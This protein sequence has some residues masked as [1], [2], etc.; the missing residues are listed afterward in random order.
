MRS[1]G[2]RNKRICFVI[3][4]CCNWRCR[5]LPLTLCGTS[6]IT[7]WMHYDN[8]GRKQ[9]VLF[10]QQQQQ[11]PYKKKPF[12]FNWKESEL[13]FKLPIRMDEMDGEIADN[14]IHW[15]H[16]VDIL[17]LVTFLHLP[18]QNSSPKMKWKKNDRKKA[19]ISGICANE[20]RE[21]FIKHFYDATTES[22]LPNR[23][24]FN[25]G[26]CFIKND[27]F[28]IPERRKAFAFNGFCLFYCIV[29]EREKSLHN[30]KEKKGK[31]TKWNPFRYTQNW[32]SSVI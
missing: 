26:I 24:F 31:Q 3:V 11:Q 1:F 10:E 32:N 23:E 5:L 18:W 27:V 29:Y 14:R 2:L 25:A 21:L 8:N 4:C 28:L 15:S 22:K 9:K 20:N 13:K 30:W 19:C 12:H 17:S 16:C 6:A 7:M